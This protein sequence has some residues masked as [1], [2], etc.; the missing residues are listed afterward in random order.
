MKQSKLHDRIPLLQ[1]GLL[2]KQLVNGISPRCWPCLNSI[3]GAPPQFYE[4]VSPAALQDNAIIKPLA[5]QQVFQVHSNSKPQPNQ[6]IN[7][8]LYFPS[9]SQ[10]LTEANLVLA[11]RLRTHWRTS[12][13]IYTCEYLQLV[14]VMCESM[15]RTFSCSR[16]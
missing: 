14:L 6:S 15:M 13:V 4:Q 1:P 8:C 12:W 11:A 5:L 16:F 3:L 7:H 2:V 9:M 10:N